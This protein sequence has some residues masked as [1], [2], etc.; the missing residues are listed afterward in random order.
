LR[1][2]CVLM[3]AATLAAAVEFPTLAEAAG[4][5]R[6]ALEA[7]AS[8]DATAALAAMPALYAK[9]TAE[10]ER[11]EAVK[12]AGQAAK[13]KDLSVRHGAFAAL[14]EFKAKGSSKYLGNWLKPPKKFKEEV[15]PSYLEAI[16]A[17]GNIADP[18]SLAALQELADHSDIP[19]AK[20]ATLAL[21]G[22]SGL[23]TKRR[24]ALAF[25]L[26]DRLEQLSAQQRRKAS[27]E[28]YARKAEL[29]SATVQALRRLTG[30]DR[31]TAEGWKAWKE[32]AEKE[33]DPF[34]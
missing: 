6:R 27:E 31:E 9:A 3:A 14:G 25:D 10:E 24:K 12:A 17:A 11:E 26:V 5:L 16:R 4:A 13:S 22:F 15:P 2:L 34:N 20:E 21:G 18:T 1:I 8:G 32:S 23:P 29:A 30:A 7:D 19:V 33:S 28:V